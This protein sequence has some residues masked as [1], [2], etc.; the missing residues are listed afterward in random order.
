M[1][2]L[3][4]AVILSVLEKKSGRKDDQLTIVKLLEEEVKKKSDELVDVKSAV[5]AEMQCYLWRFII[6]RRS[7]LYQIIDA[8][9]NEKLP[10]NYWIGNGA[11]REFS[12]H[13]SEKIVRLISIF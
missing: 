2:Y 6:T 1:L 13:H 7:I 8:I 11:R 12:L 5:Q 3:L 4:L 9:F 10:E